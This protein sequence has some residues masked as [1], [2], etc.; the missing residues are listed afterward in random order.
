MLAC[1]EDKI[2]DET[3]MIKNVS[4]CHFPFS[5]HES[6]STIALL[7]RLRSH[8]LYPTIARKGAKFGRDKICCDW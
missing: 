8:L 6:E 3:Q 4:P 7:K 5:L 2:V 1:N